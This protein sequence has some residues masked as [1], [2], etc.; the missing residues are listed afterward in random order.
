MNRLRVVFVVHSLGGGGA[1]RLTANLSNHWAELGHDVSVVT[2]ASEEDAYP[3]RGV[4]RISLGLARPSMHGPAALVA[5]LGRAR[6]LRRVVDDLRPDVVIGVMT[7]SNVLVALASI[8]KKHRVVGTEHIDPVA[9]PLPGV[10][11]VT[12]QFAYRLV[13]VVTAPTSA[14]AEWMA[15]NTGARSARALPNPVPWPLPATTPVLPPSTVLSDH[16]QVVLGVGR[17]VPQK[18]FDLLIHAFGQAAATRSNCSLVILGEGP[19]RQAL[20]SLAVEAGL[21]DRIHLPGWAGNLG[22]WFERASLYVLSSRF[23]GFGNT[24]VEAMAYRCPVVSFDCKVGP[25]EIITHNDDG[26]LVPDGDVEALGNEIAR[27]LSSEDLRRAL[28]ERGRIRSQRYAVDRI[29][30]EWFELFAELGCSGQ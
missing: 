28:G 19:D 8:G 16:E 26:L 13:D 1:E 4:A 20:Q 23:E 22:E 12:R 21:A 9:Y 25:A 7:T 2:I 5:N 18:G 17:L 14:T 6:A 29:S 30:S 27:M 10:W 11:R 3:L 24:I 15:A